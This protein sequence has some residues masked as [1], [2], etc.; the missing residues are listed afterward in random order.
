MELS[1]KEKVND[2]EFV[3]LSPPSLGICRALAMVIS[4]PPIP[5]NSPNRLTTLGNEVVNRLG[6]T[7]EHVS[8]EESSTDHKKLS[9]G[10]KSPLSTAQISFL[11]SSQLP[12]KPPND[13]ND[14]CHST[15]PTEASDHEE[16]HQHPKSLCPSVPFYISACHFSALEND[17]DTL[18]TRVE[19]TLQG[20]TD[21]DWTYFPLEHSVSPVTIIILWLLSYQATNC[22]V[23]V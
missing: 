14:S 21:L 12:L 9:V 19:T 20:F 1:R 13:S 22:L 16:P 17:Y 10:G 5:L 7:L 23:A 6:M 11:S 2:Q 15:V 8:L 4:G 3:A 18:K